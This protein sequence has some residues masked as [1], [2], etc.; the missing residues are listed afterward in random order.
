[1]DSIWGTLFILSFMFSISYWW[2]RYRRKED[3]AQHLVSVLRELTSDEYEVTTEEH[4]G[5]QLLQLKNPTTRI[6]YK[7]YASHEELFCSCFF[8]NKE[9]SGANATTV[10][11]PLGVGKGLAEISF[12]RTNALMGRVLYHQSGKTREKKVHLLF[13]TLKTNVTAHWTSSMF[14]EDKKEGALSPH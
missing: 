13:D 6:Q 10:S 3:L 7:C 5:M 9:I 4:D 2:P 11:R 14:G 1:M 8:E 12:L